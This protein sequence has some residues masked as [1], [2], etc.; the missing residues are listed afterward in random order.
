M[1]GE[2]L[3]DA[4]ALDD[5]PVGSQRCVQLG[6]TSVLICRTE[7]GVFA[8]ENR[9]SHAHRPLAG[10]RIREGNIHCPV[11]G[12]RFRLDTGMPV[13]A[14]FLAPVQSY[15]VSVVDGRVLV[16]GRLPALGG[17][18]PPGCSTSSALDR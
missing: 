7:A 8:L 13:R 4:G 15:H 6:P 12:A 16:A 9:C 18:A 5:L 2:E 1:T 11:H 3:H 10:G 17:V 14:P